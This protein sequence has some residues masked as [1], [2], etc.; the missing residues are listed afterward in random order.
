MSNPDEYQKLI[1]NLGR[2][3]RLAN[4]LDEVEARF[5][6]AITEL[7]SECYQEDFQALQAELTEV[8]SAIEVLAIRHPEWFLKTKTL[9]TPF[10][11]VASRSTTKLEVKNEDATIAL[12]ELRGEDGKPFL[13]ERKYISIESLEALDDFE[14]TRLGVRRVTSDKITISPAK[15]D[16][17]KALK[18]SEPKT[19]P[20]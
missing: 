10:G 13:R 7:I 8:E 19:T 3:T 2:Y 9:K 12:I 18:K 16:L 11:T 17:G 6:L 1:E 14:L 5:Q 20:E 4:Q 15:V